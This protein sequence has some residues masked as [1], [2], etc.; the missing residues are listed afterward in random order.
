MNFKEKLL[1][2]LLK[3]ALRRNENFKG[4]HEGETCYIFGN[5]GSLKNMEL[6][7]FVDHVSIGVNFLCLHNDFRSLNIQYYVLPEAYFLY[8]CWHNTYIHKYQYENALGKL[9]KVAFLSNYVDIPLFTSISNL[10]GSRSQNTYYLYHFGH[11]QPD[12]NFCDMSAEFS[13]M[14]GGLY[15]GIGLAI[16]MGFKKAILVGCDYMFSPSRSGHFYTSQSSVSTTNSENPYEKL[17]MECKGLID[18]EVIT[19][20]GVSSWLP[21]RD[22]ESFTGR[23]IRYRDNSEIVAPQYLKILNRAFELKQLPG[24]VYST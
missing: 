23:K 2:L 5:G 4:R 13:F 7:A 1:W 22:Y 16:N 24:A 11:R 14:A 8:P 18:L 9:F 15:T 19:D 3:G 21:Y 17:L 10:F 12:R 20:V 6:S